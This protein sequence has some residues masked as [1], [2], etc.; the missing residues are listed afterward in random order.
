MKLAWHKNH[1]HNATIIAAHIELDVIRIEILC[2]I[3][4]GFV[5]S[6]VENDWAIRYTTIR[7]LVM[8]SVSRQNSCTSSIFCFGI[9]CEYWSDD[10]CRLAVPNW[11]SVCRNQSVRSFISATIS[12]A[13]H[14]KNHIKLITF[15]TE[16]TKKQHVHLQRWIIDGK[17][18]CHGKDLFKHYGII[19][20]YWLSVRYQFVA[21]TWA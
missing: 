6:L 17:N 19:I 2:K 3:W 21:F 9:R 20:I 15:R 1:W 4:D 8:M 5:R 18:F 14:G 16:C 7:N 11:L 10:H 13:G 12:N